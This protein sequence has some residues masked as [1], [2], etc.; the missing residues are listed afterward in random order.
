MSSTLAKASIG[1]NLA[2]NLLS[3]FGDRGE[4]AMN[5]DIA[6]NNAAWA[7]V[8]AAR[9]A[10]IAEMNAQRTE[11]ETRLTLEA[12]DQE[13]KY[14]EKF[15]RR[16]LSG[17]RGEL[18]VMNRS[19]D[20]VT[21]EMTEAETFVDL[22]VVAAE[23]RRRQTEF[24]GANRAYDE[25]LQGQ[26]QLIAGKRKAQASL[27]QAESFDMQASDYSFLLGAAAETTAGIYT[28][29]KK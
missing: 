18:A 21:S 10:E 11:A 17:L 20:V 24:A 28:L 4:A 25:R 8:I 22:S 15:L 13:S 16:D 2:G 14:T 3:G 7:K 29:K 26:N 9:N 5:A 1:L 12:M 23:N 6:R 19:Q 27:L